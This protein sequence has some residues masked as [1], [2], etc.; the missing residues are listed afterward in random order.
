LI[1]NSAAATLFSGSLGWPHNYFPPATTVGYEFAVGQN[2]LSVST[3]GFAYTSGGNG[4]Q[5]DSS[6]GIWGTGGSLLTSVVIPA[7]GQVPP[8]GTDYLWGSLSTPLTLNANTSYYIGVRSRGDYEYRGYLP[9]YGYTGGGTLQLNSADITIIGSAESSESSFS[10]PNAIDPLANANQAIIGPNIQ[11][12][13]IPNATPAPTP[14]A[15]PEPST[16][17][18]F[19]IG[20][21]GL[22]MVLR[23]KKTA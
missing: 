12:S 6:V 10:F 17:A 5:Y 1:G 14:D 13:V 22:L 16:Y 18:L 15:V 20:A 7:T 19:G 4:E 11:Y 2:A 21:I 9:G 23:R 3:L 8:Y